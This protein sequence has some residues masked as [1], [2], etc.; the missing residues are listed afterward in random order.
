MIRDPEAP[1]LSIGV[2][3]GIIIPLLQQAIVEGRPDE[4]A[5]GHE[6]KQIDF[7]KGAN[8]VDSAVGALGAVAGILPWVQY[9]QLLGQYLRLMARHAEDKASKAVLRAVCAVLDGFYFLPPVEEKQTGVEA[10]IEDMQTEEPPAVAVAVAALVE[11]VEHGENVEMVV[12][13]EGNGK[14]VLPDP[15]EVYRMLSKRVVPELRGQ[16]VTK[17]NVRAPVAQALVKVLKLLP[18]EMMR[19]EL[20][21]TL[22]SVANLLKLRLQRFRDDARAVLVAM[23]TDLGPEYFPFTLEVLRSA[24]PDRGYT[25]HILGYTVHAVL[26][27]VAPKVAAEPGSIDD[28]L[29]MIIPVVEVSKIIVI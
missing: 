7:D 13:S 28:C 6:T 22:Q 1:F 4:D 21:R 17:E 3:V 29:P 10:G 5:A 11:G 24:L 20:P 9:Q 27:G 14:S 26:E 25:A 16:M 12:A 19:A 15:A 18:P 8:V 23:A 2:L